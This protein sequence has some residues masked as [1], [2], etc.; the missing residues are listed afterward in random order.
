MIIRDYLFAEI[1]NVVGGI[2]FG[3]KGS[4]INELLFKGRGALN[5]VS[6][7]VEG[8]DAYEVCSW[9]PGSGLMSTGCDRLFV[10]LLSFN[11]WTIA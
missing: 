11:L 4:F 9:R 3:T 6:G 10:L 7:N 8:V 1:W 2:V 5:I